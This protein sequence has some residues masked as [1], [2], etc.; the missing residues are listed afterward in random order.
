V[1]AALWERLQALEGDGGEPAARQA[2]AEECERLAARVRVLER[3]QARL[4]GE[5]DAERRRSGAAEARLQDWRAACAAPHDVG[6]AAAEPALNDR[7]VLCVG[8]RA[9]SVPVY[10]RLIER[11]GARFL[12]HDGGE[13]EHPSLLDR[14]LAS[15]DLVI[16][17]TGCISHDAYWRV[18]DHCKRTGKRCVF[19][20][21]PSRSGLQRALRV[22][23]STQE[24]E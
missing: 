8:G 23:A 3:T 5:L 18:K 17:Q 22:L 6:D 15:A 12:H 11:V 9:A 4:H 1:V 19:V 16:C 20:E 13:H 14:T 24:G 21:N 10:R 2:L 7:A